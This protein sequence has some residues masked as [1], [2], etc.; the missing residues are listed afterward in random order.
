MDDQFI[1][2]IDFKNA[3]IFDSKFPTFFYSFF[4]H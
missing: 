1:P 2:L 4:Y 3:V